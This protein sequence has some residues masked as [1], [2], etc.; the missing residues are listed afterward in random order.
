MADD[1][2]PTVA[3]VRPVAR[4]AN[5]WRSIGNYAAN[6]AESSSGLFETSLHGASTAPWRSRFDGSRRALRDEVSGADVI[7]LTHQLLTTLVG[8]VGP[9]PT[10]VTM[11]DLIPVMF[12]A[13]RVGLDRVW[14]W[15]F[16]RSA[17]PLH[18]LPIVIANSE[19]TSL[20]AQRIFEVSAERIR[21]VH[22][23]VGRAFYAARESPPPPLDLLAGPVVLSVG[24]QFPNKN[25][26]L[27]LHALARPQLAGVALLRVGATF[28]PR[29]AQLVA[30]LGLESRICELGEVPLPTLLAA[31]A[32]STVLAQPSI[33]EGFGMPV[34]EAMALGLPVV[35]SDAGALPE[36]AAGAA[37]T[38]HLEARKY[39]AVS[40]D[41]ATRLADA[42][43]SVMESPV[44]QARL[45]AAGTANAE[46][47]H[48]T[49]IGPQLLSTYEELQ[50]L[51]R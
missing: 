25:L 28:T 19:C 43:A 2:R 30:S 33:Y 45:R 44:E 34:A 21:V 22:V 32:S 6:I 47:F 4:T 42:L 31:M 37:R 20:D 17:Q 18:R 15:R 26:P 12:H 24:T 23:S 50:R 7:H 48:P 1:S 29:Q 5:G 40:G 11:H 3:L 46:R 35:C 51:W 10:V 13:R 36:V 39:H 14:S 8:S 41:D 27:L 49:V 9:A 16:S 38:F